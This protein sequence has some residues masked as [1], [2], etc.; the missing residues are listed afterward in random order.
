VSTVHRRALFVLLV[1]GVATA[2]MAGALLAGRSQQPPPQGPDDFQAYFLGKQFEKLP[3][4]RRLRR[5]DRRPAPQ[6]FR[7]NYIS[8]IYGTCEL[9]GDAGCAPP[10]EVQNWPACERNPTTYRLTPRGD[11]VPHTDLSIRGAPAALFE[12]GTRLEIYTGRTTVVIFGND[13]A[14]IRRAADVLQSVDGR[15]KPRQKFPPPDPGAV[16]GQIKCSS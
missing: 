2:V 14:Q 8:F 13:P 9:V 3:L 11:P 5:L 7:A 6:E 16:E 10:I 15:I 12:E 4:T 1:I